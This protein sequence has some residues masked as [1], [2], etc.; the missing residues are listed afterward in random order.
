MTGGLGTTPATVAP[1]VTQSTNKA[2][3]GTF[4]LKWILTPYIALMANFV[5]TRFDTPVV[6]NGITLDA[7]KAFI[8]RA[9]FDFY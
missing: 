1:A 8:M 9:Q 4:A 7:E 5:Y 2:N 3:A 6:A